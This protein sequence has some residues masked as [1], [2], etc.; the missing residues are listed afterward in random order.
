MRFGRGGRQSASGNPSRRRL[1]RLAVLFATAFTIMS[2]VGYVTL[3]FTINGLP[4]YQPSTGWVAVLEPDT[5]PRGDTVQLLVEAETQGGQTRAIYEVVVCGT[6]PYTGDLLIGGSAM[7]TGFQPLLGPVPPGPG[8][9]VRVQQIPDLKFGIGGA[10]GIPIDLGA[11]QL[12]RVSMAHVHA[13]PPAAATG[14]A[15]SLPSGVS[16]GITGVTASPFEQSWAG[17]WD[18][19]HGPHISQVWPLTGTLPGV[20]PSL[21]GQFTALKGLSGNWGR[22]ATYFQVTAGG[23]PVT[24]SVDSTSP[25]P[26]STSP[27]VWQSTEPVSPMARLTDSSSLAVLQNFVVLFAVVFGIAGSMLASLLFEWL[28]PRSHQDDTPASSG[29]QPQPITATSAQ[30]LRLTTSVAPAGRWLALVGIFILIRYARNR[31]TRSRHDSPR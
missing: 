7:L 21:Y 1:R 28:R 27:L 16:E 22:S 4:S 9:S 11:V 5:T 17:W 26:A 2:T 8:S 13:C 31:L 29:S 10:D 18:W 24:W 30:H 23:D 6:R 20:M 3:S 19:W 12:V 25:A 14:A 15:G